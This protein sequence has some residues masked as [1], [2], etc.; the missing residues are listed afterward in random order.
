MSEQYA[1]RNA[2][3]SKAKLARLKKEGKKTKVGKGKLTAAKLR[4]KAS[5]N[6][7]AN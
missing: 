1:G 2:R 6:Q 3:R 5:I 7:K 4:A